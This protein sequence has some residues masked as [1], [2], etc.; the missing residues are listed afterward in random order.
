MGLWGKVFQSERSECK[1]TEVEASQNY[2]RYSR[3][4]T[5]DEAKGAIGVKIVSILQIKEL[6][7]V[8]LI[9][10]PNFTE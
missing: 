2:L 7:T 1:G 10:L 9:H 5:G 4:F 8:H 3:E 6:E